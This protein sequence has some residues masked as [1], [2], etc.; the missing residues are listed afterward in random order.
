MNPHWLPAAPAFLIACALFILPGLA[1]RLAGWRLSAVG[2]YFL[3]PVLS[4]AIVAVASNVSPVL[5]VA[6][7]PLPVVAITAVAT[8][9]AWALRRWVNE[10]ESS[11]PSARVVAASI[12]G[13]I[14]AATVMV[15]QLAYVFV[16]PE[17]ISQTF[18][19][20]VHLNAIRLALDA[21]D[22]SAF[23]IGRTSDIGFYPNA[24][25]SF[26]T[27]TASMTG[28]P[29]TMAVNATNV[30][31][32]A[33]VWPVSCM[34]LGAAFFR[35]RASALI[36]SAALSTAF[37]AFPILLLSFGVLYPNT[38]GYAVL[39]AG[40]AAVWWLLTSSGARQ[41]T[42]SAIV[43]LV[44]CAAIGLGHPN[45]FL[46]LFAIGTGL[47][48]AELGRRA[49]RDHLARMWVTFA[50]ASVSLLAVGAALWK[51]ARTGRVMS[52]WGPWTNAGEALLQGALVS[53][54]GFPITVTTAILLSVGVVA[55]VIRPRRLVFV[56][57]FLVTLGM[58]VVVSGTSYSAWRDALTN[59]WYN[60]SFRLA[61]LLPITGIPV[62][63]MGALTI[64][65]VCRRAARR[66]PIPRMVSATVGV[67]A[68]LALF[69]VGFGANVS[70][71]AS[72]ARGTY[73]LTTS[74][75]LLTTDE[76]SLL[77][78]LDAETPD[79]A[80]IL[81]NPWTGTSL[82]L[83]IADR[84]VVERHVFGVRSADV[85]YLDENLTHIDTDPAVCTAVRRIGVTHVLDFGSQNVFND[86]A[87]GLDRSGLD[88]LPPSSRLVLVDSQ[89]D[90]ARL[91]RIEGC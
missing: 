85:L 27:L 33:I 22:A 54:R 29:V 56:V 42:L 73:E 43:L 30:A 28:S 16:G 81:G 53:P 2:P 8:L 44:A 79:N 13:V 36:A 48:I 47:T 20:I 24:W 65:D 71:T 90:A 38:M 55:A 7:S 87:A 72:W 3:V 59:P 83:A 82:A 1:V 19:N 15:S 84:T 51:F 62:A 66:V 35:S 31:I 67:L 74:S 88:D 52:Q 61:A 80:V 86:P 50:A 91:F 46:A 49:V 6:W 14:V 25:H 37:G 40:I 21:S 10:Q 60:D 75:A 78:R 57:P 4:T 9:A 41:V 68:S 39:P 34:A 5:H 26:V 77:G 17:N 69:T 76:M 32:G 89:G 12:A 58:F 64:V 23:Q 63:T 11:A 45:A 70:A 18:D